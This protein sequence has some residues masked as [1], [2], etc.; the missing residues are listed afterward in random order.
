M[1]EKFVSV[2]YTDEKSMKSAKKNTSFYY[3]SEKCCF[4]TFL[5]NEGIFLPS[6]CGG[7]G[8]CIQ[9]T[10]QVNSGGG[11]ILPTEKPYF[12]RKEIQDNWRL[13]CQVK[14]KNINVT[15]ISGSP[16]GGL[17]ISTLLIVAP[18]KDDSITP[19]LIF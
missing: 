2:P 1:K 11:E 10:C 7:G 6:A 4:C 16:L 18:V 13:G 15:G 5:S 19:L 3:F 9:C 14:I 12:T 8:T 17:I